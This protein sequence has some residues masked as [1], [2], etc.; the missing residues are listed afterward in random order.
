MSLNLDTNWIYA[1]AK[2][3]KQKHFT[4]WLMLP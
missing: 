1:T 3:T 2:L 4:D